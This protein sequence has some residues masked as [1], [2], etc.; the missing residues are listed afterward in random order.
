MKT[1]LVQIGNSRGIR[2][3]KPLLEQAGLD[4]EVE[5]ALQDGGI[6]IM[7]AIG[8]PR[9]GWSDAAQRMQKR[10]DDELMDPPTTTKFDDEEW[11]W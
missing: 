9:A 3:P 4:G 2:L 1:R 5:I 7:P 8:A 11:E 6:L 10:G